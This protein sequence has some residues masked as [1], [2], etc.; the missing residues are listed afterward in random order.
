VR[1]YA[2]LRSI[3][4]EAAAAYRRDVLEGTFPAA[5]HGFES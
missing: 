5:E 2:D 1:Q 4:G 3:V